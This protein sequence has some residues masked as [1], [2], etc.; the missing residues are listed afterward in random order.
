MFAGIPAAICCVRKSS[1][2]TSCERRHQWVSDAESED[3]EN[4]EENTQ[5][6]VDEELTTEDEGEEASEM[7]DEDEEFEDDDEDYR[8]EDVEEDIDEDLK[9]RYLNISPNKTLKM[10]AVSVNE[11]PF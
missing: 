3:I 8:D 9:N 11:D 6:E 2:G 10:N 5:E 7:D 4:E 1:P